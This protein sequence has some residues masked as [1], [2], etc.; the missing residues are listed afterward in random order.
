MAVD[1]AKLALTAQRLIEGN[2]RSVT[3]I[4]VSETPIDPNEPWRGNTSAETTAVANAVLSSYDKED[5]DGDLIRAGD[6][7]AVVAELSVPGQDIEDFEL[8]RDDENQEWKIINVTKVRPGPT[9]LVFVA[10]LR[11]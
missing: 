1:Y 8:L 6:Q 9:T 11:K 7:R 2:G 10:Q 4:K 5:I 3:F